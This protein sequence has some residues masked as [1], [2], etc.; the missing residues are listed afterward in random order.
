MR[1]GVFGFL[2]GAALLALVSAAFA[3]T[4]PVESGCRAG[5]IC[6][7]LKYVVYRDP[8]GVPV[9][10]KSDALANIEAINRVW[11]RCR[12]G[13]QIEEYLP[14]SPSEYKLNFTTRN[15]VELDEIRKSFDRDG[16]LLVVT[17]GKWDRRGTLGS[18]TANAWTAMPGMGP[19]GAILEAPVGRFANIIAHELGH[20]LNLE[21]VNDAS[22]LMN[23]IIYGNSTV[24][25]R[26]QCDTAYTSASRF[27][28]RQEAGRS[29]R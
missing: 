6:L 16:D 29:P 13:F 11:D 5:K 8:E 10:S 28:P 7:G 26:N 2:S 3:A 18:S 22:D 25:T 9:V 15:S 20:Y 19:F 27:E 24:L 1:V 14:V 12:I 4:I 17:T 23:P 21:H